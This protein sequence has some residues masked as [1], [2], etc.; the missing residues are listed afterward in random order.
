MRFL[1]LI[2]DA[3]IIGIIRSFLIV[4]V[5][6]A[7]GIGLVNDLQHVDPDRPQ[8]MI[9]ILA[10]IIAMAGIVS[11]ISTAIWVLYYALMESSKFQGSVGKIALGIIVVDA[12]GARL[13][14][15]KAL[16]RNLCKIIS[17]FILCIGFIIAAFTEKKQ[18]LHDMIANTFVIRKPASLNEGVLDSKS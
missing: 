3:I 1:A 13:D 17:G 15:T 11:L 8:E 4:P 7:M 14:F 12:H 16:V 6:A 5:L 18:A 10:P 9:G 2:I